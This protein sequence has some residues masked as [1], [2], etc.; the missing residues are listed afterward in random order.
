MARCKIVSL[1]KQQK[2]RGENIVWLW[3][4]SL[5]FQNEI[6]FVKKNLAK[7]FKLL[8][9]VLQDFDIGKSVSN[10]RN[11]LAWSTAILMETLF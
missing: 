11:L 1:N 6:L 9:S 10:S 2:L 5:I 8:D 7:I 4:F 3:S